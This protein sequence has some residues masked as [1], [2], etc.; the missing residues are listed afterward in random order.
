MKNEI[1]K[2][3]KNYPYYQVSNLGRVKSLQRERVIGNNKYIQE[4]R[5]LK[6]EIIQGYV[7]VYLCKNNKNKG[8][9]VHKI[10]ME[11]FVPD[12]SNF[13][14][15]PDE[16]RNKINLDN[17][18]INHIDEN[19]LNNRVDNLEWCTSKY[20]A[21]Y[22]ERKNNIAKSRHK[23]IIQYDLQGNYI[24][25]W[26]S[27]IE[28]SNELNIIDTSICKCLKGKRNK[29]GGYIWRYADE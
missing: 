23:P 16:D 5:I 6:N 10:V 4:E 8:T 25:T 7:Y 2:D 3:I 19:K 24:K 17:L 29:A 22:G 27:I 9:R 21:N 26:D 11:T 1:W 13:K 15:M 12:R 14:S 20:N 18:V 28:A